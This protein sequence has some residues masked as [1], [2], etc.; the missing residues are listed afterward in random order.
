MKKL[1]LLLLL[2]ILNVGYSQN[3][4][5]SKS[6]GAI[7]SSEGIISRLYMGA[8]FGLTM[9][10]EGFLNNID[11]TNEYITGKT[12]TSISLNTGYRFSEK[13]GATIN[14]YSSG[15]GTNKKRL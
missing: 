2:L 10:P 5:D 7:K 3:K 1:L 15:I 11:D 14:L 8:S 6:S 13:W 12:G 9:F 4:L